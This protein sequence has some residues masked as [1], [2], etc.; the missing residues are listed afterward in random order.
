MTNGDPHITTLV[1]N[2]LESNVLLDK[3]EEIQHAT[4]FTASFGS[5]RAHILVFN[6]GAVVVQG[7]LS[8]L[9]TW[10]QQVKTSISANR[11]IPAFEPPID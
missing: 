1:Q 11:P 6:T 8:P 4:K 2:V 3:Q 7:R 5:L 10:L 9:A